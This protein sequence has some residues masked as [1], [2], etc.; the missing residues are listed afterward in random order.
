MTRIDTQRLGELIDTHGAALTLYARQWC[1]SPEDALQEALIDLLRQ[2]PV[3]NHPIAWLYKTVR[4]R[5]MNLARAERRRVKHHRQACEQRKSWFL[6][7]DGMS[8]EPVDAEALL[9]RLPPLE[10]EIVVARVWGELSFGQIA[11]LVD[12]S[13]S[14]VHRRYQRALAELGRIMTNQLEDSRQTDEPRPSFL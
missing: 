8:D 4:R 11:D 6:P 5:A 9:R 3:P 1:R 13:T 7:A 14:A 2:T 10:R 12:R